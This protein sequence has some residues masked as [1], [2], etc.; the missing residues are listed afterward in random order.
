MREAKTK[1]RSEAGPV[2]SSAASA[3]RRHPPSR[4]SPR[5]SGMIRRA[6]PTQHF[7]LAS[8]GAAPRSSPLRQRS[9]P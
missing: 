9:R 6:A 3:P 1:V 4:P 7:P 8:S 5:G 2:D